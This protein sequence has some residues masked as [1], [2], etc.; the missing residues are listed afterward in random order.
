E[1][2]SPAMPQKFVYTSSTSVYGQTDGSIVTE[3]SPADPPTDTGRVLVEAERLLLDAAQQHGLP[4]VVLRVAGIYGPGRGYWFKQYL[5]GTAT[6]EG[7]GQRVL[8]MIHR[9]DVAGAI[10]AALRKGRPGQIYNAVDDEPVTQLAF[11]Q[12][13]SASTD[14][15]LPPFVP[16]DPDV[17]RKRGLTNKRVS[18]RRLKEELGYCF[19]YPTFREGYLV[20]VRLI[21]AIASA[22]K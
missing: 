1:W 9:D 19:Q 18:N 2:L 21:Q 11:F 12:W 10:T 15:P 13:L 22:R 7:A 17:A 4:A 3:A 5:A 6:I 20:Q 8:N 14:R 16:E